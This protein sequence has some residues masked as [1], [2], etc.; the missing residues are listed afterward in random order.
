[1]SPSKFATVSLAA[2]AMAAASLSGAHAAETEENALD[3]IV[4]VANDKAGLIERAPTTTINGID[5]PLIETARSASFASDLTMQRY[6][7]ETVDDLVAVSPGAFTASF[8][9]VPGS[10][11]LRGTLAEVY[12]RGFKRIE[13]RGN[14]PTILSAT[15]QVE[16]VRGPPTAFNGPGKVGGFL[17][18][19]PK[20][21]RVEG[22]YL[23]AVTGAV[24]AVGGSYGKKNLSAE[25]GLPA[26]VGSVKGGVYA[27]GEL[28]DS[29]SYYRGVTPEHQLVQL[30]ADFSTDNGFFLA[31]GGMFF[32]SDGYVQTPGWNRLTQD[33]VDNQTY[34]RG[35]DTTIV[36]RDGN[37][38][39]T[40]N[41]IGATLTRGYTPGVVPA[42]D[43]R[44]VL[45]T[46]LGV[47]KIS[48]RDVFISDA[49][50]AE[51]ETQTYYVD[52][53]KRFSEK[54]VLKAQVF[55]DRLATKRFVSYGFPAAYDTWV[56]E[57]RLTYNG[58]FATPDRELVTKL[59]T[60][61]SWR[62][63][64]G[65]RKESNSFIGLDRRDILAG[66]TPG[67]IFDSP[68]T[69][70]PGNV[71]LP[72]NLYN[73]S[74]W[75]DRSVFGVA[76]ITIY[77]RLNLVFGGRYDDYSVKSQDIGTAASAVNRRGFKDARGK[78]TYQLSASYKLP[79][80]LMPY[81]T[82]AETAAL[83]V[84]Q[85]GDINPAQVSNKSWVSDSDLREA[86]VKG[87]WFDGALLASFSAYRQTR[88]ALNAISNTIVGHR[89][90]GLELELRWVASKNLSFSFN[91]NSQKTIVKGPDNGFVYIPS[92]VALT[93]GV[94]GFGGGYAVFAYSSFPE[95][96]VDYELTTI[97]RNVATLYSTYTSDEHGWGRAGGTVG[98][99]YVSETSG[100]VPGAVKYPSYATVAAS[101][102]WQKELWTVS[103]N[104]D[105][106][107]NKL[108]FT[109]V[110]DV[111]A[112]VAVLP[113]KGRE[114][115][116]TLRR[117]F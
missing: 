90:K 62:T 88:T 65:N 33:L 29:G 16:I 18:F 12:F 80:G 63:F 58:E 57:G 73:I 75:H 55:Y 21:A 26:N 34:V 42:I 96:R 95:R 99:R 113:S 61:L 45:D 71:G 4:V 85:A 112:N 102:F 94:T 82:Y 7:I 52:F 6:G 74:K 77:D 91:G 86:G 25:I 105:N 69:D 11:S 9:N 1:M 78:G 8:Y 116:V 31:F 36:D 41:E 115:R 39:L 44:F 19:V 14:Y 87:Q 3:E 110:A 79:L 107:L 54:H 37:G 49:D 92:Y 108:Y 66:A 111:Y 5:K 70:E 64:E 47:S 27:Y 2:L 84:S 40:P 93:S 103:L 15:E 23:T 117:S 97:P 106:V 72:W 53:G 101:A 50:F 24:Q 83:E 20:T 56:A 89:A 22:A 30:S 10:V 13:N 98:V 35:R 67:D 114:W 76:D 100:T 109:P 51:A 48:P 38:R 32:N 17:N 43:Q 68:F 46:G 81:V 104:V 28:E 60:G 59:V